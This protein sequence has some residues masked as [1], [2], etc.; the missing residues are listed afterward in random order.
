[1]TNLIPEVLKM[2]GLKKD[3]FFKIKGYNEDYKY[4]FSEKNLICYYPGGLRAEV[5]NVTLVELLNG[6]CE[7]IKLPFKPKYGEWYTHLCLQGCHHNFDDNDDVHIKRVTW[8]EDSDDFLNFNIGNC[9]PADYNF[10]N[11]EKTE[12]KRKLV[13]KYNEQ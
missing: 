10:T 5:V 12:F 11:E 6:T 13:E 4:A 3:E 8:T 9:Y 1:M 2:L 7:V